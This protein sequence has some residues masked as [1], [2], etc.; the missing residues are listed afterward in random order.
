MAQDEIGHARSLYPLLEDLAGASEGTQ[1]E[2]R[3]RFVHA[4]FLRQPFQSWTDFVAANFMFDTALTVLLEAAA[5]SSLGGLAQRARRMIEEER[6]HWLHGEGWTRRLSREGSNVRQALAASFNRI[7]PE[8]L[9]WFDAATDEL[10]SHGVVSQGAADL[11][12][13]YRA[14]VNPILKAAGLSPL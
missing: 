11:R 7:A 12:A 2:T 3:T 9:A 14:R 6:L 10:M 8:A 13:N 5:D 4:P 1:P